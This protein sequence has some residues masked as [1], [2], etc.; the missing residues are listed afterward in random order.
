MPNKKY[1][2]NVDIKSTQ[3][4]NGLKGIGVGAL[5]L[6]SAGVVL[7]LGGATVLSIQGIYEYNQDQ[8][9][10]K[11]PINITPFST[12]RTIVNDYENNPTRYR[13]EWEGK[14]A[15]I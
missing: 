6:L 10:K 11:Q 12:M 7:F 15:P 14:Y 8:K 9:A 13:L 5:S 4:A 1:D 2:H 3:I